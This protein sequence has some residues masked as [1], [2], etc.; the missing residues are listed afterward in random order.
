MGTEQELKRGVCIW[1]L[2]WRTIVA[3]I[4]RVV[5]GGDAATEHYS[6][7][8]RSNLIVAVGT[9][10]GERQ[11]SECTFFMIFRPFL[12]QLDFAFSFF[13]KGESPRLPPTLSINDGMSHSMS[14]QS[15]WLN[16]N[17]MA[18]V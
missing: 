11:A 9:Y 16:K 13:R 6:I 4:A 15:Q 5:I 1:I 8:S 12:I 7:F 2:H 17:G 3:Q 10:H 18:P 14:S